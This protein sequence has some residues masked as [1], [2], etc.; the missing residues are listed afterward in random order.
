MG[1]R[2]RE[3]LLTTKPCDECDNP[4]RAAIRDAIKEIES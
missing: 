2:V 3:I 4:E 1:R